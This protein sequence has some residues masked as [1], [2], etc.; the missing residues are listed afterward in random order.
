MYNCTIPQNLILRHYVDTV[1]LCGPLWCNALFAFEGN[2]GKVKNFVYGTGGVITQIVEK[3]I[4]SKECNVYAKDAHQ[5]GKNPIL[6]QLTKIQLTDHYRNVF[7]KND[8]NLFAETVI[9]VARRLKLNGHTY[10][11]LISHE[12]KSSDFF[13]EFDS[14]MFGSAEFY[15]CAIKRLYSLS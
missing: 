13:L 4:A 11:S 15:L 10:T 3:Y 6:C 8:I 1:R 5:Y 2:I 14:Q 12:T 9:Q 7:E